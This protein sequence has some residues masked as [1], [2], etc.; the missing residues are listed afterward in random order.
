MAFTEGTD[1]F[2]TDITSAITRTE[3]KIRREASGKKYSTKKIRVDSINRYL[4]ST[5]EKHI[6]WVGS[7]QLLALMESE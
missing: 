7:R 2:K 6:G 3:T 4:V 1:V 5:F